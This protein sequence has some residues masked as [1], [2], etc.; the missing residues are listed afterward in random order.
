[1]MCEFWCCRIIQIGRIANIYMD[2]VIHT[3]WYLEGYTVLDEL[4]NDRL[5]AH[6]EEPHNGFGLKPLG[7]GSIVCFKFIEFG[8][9]GTV[10]E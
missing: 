3:G 1:M 6:W 7:R 8:S 9:K 10:A 5:A 4:R 2:G